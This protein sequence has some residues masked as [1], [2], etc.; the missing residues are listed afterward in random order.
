MLSETVFHPAPH[1][2]GTTSEFSR[3]PG[4]RSTQVPARQTAV[5]ELNDRIG[6]FV[7]TLWGVSTS[8]D[9]VGQVVSL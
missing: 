3:V 2:P 8:E 4:G 1:L 6:P 9:V 5:N 7:V